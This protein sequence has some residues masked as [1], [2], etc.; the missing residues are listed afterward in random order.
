MENILKKKEIIFIGGI[1]VVALGL[2][3]GMSLADKGAHAFIRITVDGEE[4]GTYSLSRDQTIKINDTNVCEIKDGKVRMNSAEC[5]D[6]LCMKQKAIDE[7]GGTIVCLP[8]K[9][10]IEGEKS[11]DSDSSDELSIDAVT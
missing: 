1:L 3:G 4:Y 5:P 6:H 9:V 8:N 7:K 2:W 10:V 11:S